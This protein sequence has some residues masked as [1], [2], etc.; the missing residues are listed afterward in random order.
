VKQQLPTLEN[1]NGFLSS[2]Q[3]GVTQLAIE[4]CNALVEDGALAGAYFPGFNFSAAPNTAFDAT[5][6]NQI[7]TPL[8]NRMIGSGLDTQPDQTLVRAEVNNLID[9]L[10]ACGGSCPADHTRTVVKASC[11]AVLGSAPMLLQ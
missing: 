3:M 9:R 8:L 10:T 6:R 2:H 11:A 5:G 4:Y 7:I 1:I